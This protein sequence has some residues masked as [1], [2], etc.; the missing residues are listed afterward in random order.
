M[1]ICPDVALAYVIRHV[2]FGVSHLFIKLGHGFIRQYEEQFSLDFGEANNSTQV[3]NLT[4]HITHFIRPRN[5]I[6]SEKW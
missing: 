2:Y 4:Y 1:S 3:A 6:R 5:G